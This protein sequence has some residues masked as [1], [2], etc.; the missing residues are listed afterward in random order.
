MKELVIFGTG[1]ISD[2]VSYYFEREGDYRIAAYCCDRSFLEE[3]T[4]NG[5]PVVAFENI[6]ENYPPERF[7][8]F[9]A[10]G[11]HGLNGLRKMKCSEG[12]AKGYTL[13]SYVSPYVYG[14]FTI[15]ANS[16]LLDG[17]VVQPK[18]KIGNNVFVWGGAMIGHH[19]AIQDHCWV[20]G[21]A[22]VGGLSTIGEECFLGLNATIGHGVEVGVRCLIGANTLITKP[23]AS[24]S[25]IVTSDT[26]T[27][28]LKVDQFLR[29]TSCFR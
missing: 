15:G 13:A 12:G 20:T 14:D 4:F 11:Y 2:C 10:L 21:S 24:E 29:L 19:A 5:R 27:H 25:V 17:A 26:V 22:N 23:V 28:R 6:E 8:L 7:S 18:A 16:L 9:I 1:K 3:E